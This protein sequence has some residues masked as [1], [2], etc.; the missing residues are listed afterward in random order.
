MRILLDTN[1]LLRILYGD[2]KSVSQ[3]I[4]KLISNKDNDIFVSICSV[5]EVE[6]KHL[7]KPELMPIDGDELYEALT[8]T[9]VHMLSIKYGYVSKLKDVKEEEIH[10]DPFDQ[11][12]VATALVEGLTILTSDTQIAK[13]KSINV[14]QC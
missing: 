5:W 4:V 14:I 2:R 8:E 6:I 10:S 12:L 13:Y 9:N 3:D 7:K 1:V 11:M